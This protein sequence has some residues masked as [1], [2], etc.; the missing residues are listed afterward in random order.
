MRKLVS[1]KVEALMNNSENTLSPF[2]RGWFVILFALLIIIFGIT[3]Y[4]QAVS[5]PETGQTTCYLA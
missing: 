5:L 1:N 3:P 2:G 4:T